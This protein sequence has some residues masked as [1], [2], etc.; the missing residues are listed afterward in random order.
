MGYALFPFCGRGQ[1]PRREYLL[2]EVAVVDFDA[3]HCAVEV[4]E[5][6]DGEFAGQ[7]FESHGR[8]QH[9]AAENRQRRRKY[10]LVV[11]RQ[12]LDRI[13]IDPLRALGRGVGD[14]T[15]VEL[16]QRVISHRHHAFGPY[17]VIAVDPLQL[18]AAH[19]VGIGEY[20][21]LFEVY[22]PQSGGLFEHTVGG[23]RQRLVVENHGA[24]QFE[25][26]ETGVGGIVAPLDQQ[27]FERLA[28]ETEHGAVYRQR[29]VHLDG[30]GAGFRLQT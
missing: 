29:L 28:V 7:Q 1:K 11:H 22:V 18:L 2:A 17:A 9:L 3:Q 14:G 21:H 15:G 27:H 13:D 5:R 23:L 16:H 10:L 30:H 19:P 6:A 8:L 26:V 25:L 24:R 20:I 12:P 4:L